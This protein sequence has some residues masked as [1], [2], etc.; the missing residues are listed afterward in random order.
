ML[1]GLTYDLRS[2]Y[3][4]A[5]YGEEETAEFDHEDTVAAIEAA[6]AGL[7]HRTER[8]GRLHRLVE[9]LAGGA[10]WD[11]VFNIAEGLFGIGREAQVP[12][13]LDAYEIAYT[14]SDPLVMSLTLDKG[15]TKRVIRDAGI[16]TSDFAVVHTPDAARADFAPPYFI[17]PVAEGTGKGI[18]AKSI[19]RRREDL[20]A[21]CA[22]LVARFRQPV[23][24]ERFLPGREFTVGIVGT[25][26]RAAVLG[27]IEVHLLETAE[28]HIYSYGNK[29]EYETRVAYQLVKPAADQAVAEAEAISLAAWRTLGCRDA[30]RIDIRC[31][32]SGR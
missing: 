12:A 13:L 28:A 30:G 23:L 16:P 19:V 2:E 10:R 1:V 21:A 8:I 15:M 5:G 3:L 20:P 27:T 32:E 9:Q 17:K 7:G 24:V 11:L 18:D 29:K 22:A 14:F 6:L 25:G 26:D 4:A 31:D